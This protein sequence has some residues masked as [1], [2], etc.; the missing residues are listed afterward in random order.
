M[1]PRVKIDF[2]NGALGSVAPS[3][4]GVAGL[5]CTASTVVGGLQLNTTYTLRSID[6]LQNLGVNPKSDDANAFLYKTIK[7]FFGEGGAGAELWLMCLPNTYGQSQVLDT[8]NNYAKKL[9]LDANGRIRV[10]GVAVRPTTESN[11]SN[12]L[13]EDSYTAIGKA[14]AL[15][16][17]MT[18]VK[19]APLVVLIE[20]RAFNGK[21]AELKDLGE[22]NN[23]RVG[24]LIGDSATDSKGAA[25]GL[26]LGRVA[27]VPVQRHI[28]RV[29]DGAVAADT[30]YVG[31]LAPESSD[32]ETIHNKGYITF[33]TFVGK[34]GYFFTDDSLATSSDDDYK[35][36]AR[37]RTID[38]AYRIAYGRLL[39]YVNTEIPITATSGI[40]PAFAKSIESDIVSSV[41]SDML[42]EGNLGVDTTDP[43]DKGVRC[44]VDYSQN[45]AATGRLNVV[46]QVKPYG[47]SKYIDVKLGF[48]TINS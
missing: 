45:V 38:K 32:V 28:G 21:P 39:S 20:G 25:I 4:D 10:L 31:T 6:D 24:V 22:M 34:G 44:F 23:N 27:K 15:A 3:A 16:R 5:V 11:V 33:R 37:R 48:I 43:A 12:A 35:S 42:P 26:L 13:S 46:L 18:E 8:D 17:Y 7:E 9:L 40:L 2:E 14:Q 36:I 29:S 1:L 47:Y 19:F 30:L 41:V